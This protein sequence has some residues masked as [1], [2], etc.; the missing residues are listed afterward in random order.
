MTYAALAIGLAGALFGANCYYHL[1]KW[2]RTCQRAHIAI[3]D[4]GKV[5]MHAPLTEWIKWINALD[6]DGKD[7]K[8]RVV[9]VNR[10]IR[11]AILRKGVG[12]TATTTSHKVKTEPKVAA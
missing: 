10:G 6:A 1:W 9:Y 8:G 11:V 5:Q 7:A 12:V 3:S 2:A 4:K